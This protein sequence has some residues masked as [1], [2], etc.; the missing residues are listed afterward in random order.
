MNQEAALGLQIA[1]S[2]E[3]LLELLAQ[4]T[5]RWPYLKVK[6]LYLLKTG[7]ATTLPEVAALLELNVATPQRWFQKYKEFGLKTLLTPLKSPALSGIPTWAV[8]RLWEELQ[9]VQFLPRP[10]IVQLWL[11]TVGIQVSNDTA[12]LLL[13]SLTPRLQGRQLQAG[14][15]GE[16]AAPSLMPVP[17][18][19]AADVCP[20]YEHWKQQ[21]Q[22]SSDT[23]ALSQILTEYFR[24]HPAAAVG[25]SDSSQQLTE[26]AFELDVTS[27]PAQQ[28]I[29]AQ[30]NQAHLAKRLNVQN[31]LLS[32]NRQKP[33]FTRWSQQ[34]DPDGIGWQWLPALRK[35]QPWY[36]S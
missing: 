14:G 1:E 15:T 35:Y 30:L 26:A 6:T 20:R 34:H 13:S 7:E 11:L 29:P 18:R 8:E 16:T 24:R 10:G 22:S 19:L 25:D 21:H 12:S 5:D 3:A 4:Q 23:Q 33:T 2:P 9:A 27:S 17:L 36:E 28:S 32:R 31:S